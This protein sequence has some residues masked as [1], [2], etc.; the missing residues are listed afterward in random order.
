MMIDNWNRWLL[1]L[2]TVVPVAWSLAFLGQV[3]AQVLRTFPRSMQIKIGRGGEVRHAMGI[4]LQRK[5]LINWI[6]TRTSIGRSL[7]QVE[8]MAHRPSS[9][10][11]YTF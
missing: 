4:P 10:S 7:F 9:E 6:R 2:V 1:V 8:G 11:E 5:S 3:E